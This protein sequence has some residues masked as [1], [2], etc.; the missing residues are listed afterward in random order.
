[1]IGI[2]KI[3][4]SYFGKNIYIDN[5]CMDFLN[6][7]PIWNS[8]YNDSDII[9]KLFLSDPSLFF[10]WYKLDMDDDSNIRNKLDLDYN[11]NFSRFLF[12]KPRFPNLNKLI[13]DNSIASESFD[14]NKTLKISFTSRIEFDKFNENKKTELGDHII[15]QKSINCFSFLHAI[16]DNSYFESVFYYYK[17]MA[18]GS[19]ERDGSFSAMQIALRDDAR[20]MLWRIW[21]EYLINQQENSDLLGLYYDNNKIK[22]KKLI[23]IG[24]VA[25]D[26]EYQKKNDK[27]IYRINYAIAQNEIQDRLEELEYLINNYSKEKDFQNFFEKYPDLLLKTFGPKY[28]NIHSQIVLKQEDSNIVP[29]FLL[30]RIDDGFCDILDLK[31]SNHNLR[32]KLRSHLSFKEIIYSVVSQL[33]TYRNYFDD[34]INRNL[35]FEKY[36]LKSFRPKTIAIIGRKRDYYQDI[37]RI[38]TEGLLPNHF[39]LLTYDDVKERIRNFYRII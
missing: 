14:L 33:E 22:V 30:E 35:F 8:P 16:F 39:E 17:L 32:K 34:S 24:T 21:K 13:R 10:T 19:I 9:K 1:M 5:R 2:S 4:S 28:T 25:L 36:K 7:R 3:V 29:D 37:E 27:G 38:K 26:D 31:L 11:Y 23:S 20:E 15:S 18:N 6:R 12:N